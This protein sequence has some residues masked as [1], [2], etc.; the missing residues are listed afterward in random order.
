MFQFFIRNQFQ[1][2]SVMMVFFFI[3]RLK[4]IEFIVNPEFK[5]GNI[6]IPFF[7]LRFIG[8]SIPN[9]FHR[10]IYSLLYSYIF[11]NNIEFFDCN[12]VTEII[13]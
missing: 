7:H 8:Q 1:N 6:K 11:V 12:K 10:G 2:F 13:E 4:K 9:L 3:A 5:I